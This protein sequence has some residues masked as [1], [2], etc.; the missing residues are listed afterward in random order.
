MKKFICLIAEL[1]EAAKIQQ[2]VAIKVKDHCLLSLQI[3][4]LQKRYML[5]LLT[6]HQ[7]ED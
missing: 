5:G 3:G 2:K 4:N 1:I 7:K 6:L